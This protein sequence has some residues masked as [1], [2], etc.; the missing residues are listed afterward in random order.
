MVITIFNFC[1]SL[2]PGD[3]IFAY[4]GAPR[5]VQWWERECTEGPKRRPPSGKLTT[6][7]C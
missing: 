2:K 4:V 1:F 6:L 3:F 5:G 7:D